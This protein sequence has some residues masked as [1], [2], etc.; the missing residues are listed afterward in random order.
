MRRRAEYVSSVALRAL[1]L[2]ALAVCSAACS[3]APVE[4]PASS[5]VQPKPAG[6]DLDAMDPNAAPGDD[7]YRYANGRWLDTAT[8]PQS[9]GAYGTATDLIRKARRSLILTIREA[10][11]AEY[12]AGSPHQKIGD[13]FIAYVD[14]DTRNALGMRPI[15]SEFEKIDRIASRDD[16]AWYLGDARRRG[17]PIPI[18][19]NVH[20]DAG[21]SDYY[22]L[23][24]TQAGLGLPDRD[25]YLRDDPA[26]IEVRDDYERYIA[27]MLTMA[28]HEDPESGAAL[29]LAFETRLAEQHLPREESRDWSA[30][31]KRVET[32]QLDELM[33]AFNWTLF[34]DA[35]GAAEVQ[36]VNL[37]AADY[38]PALDNIF[39]TTD[40]ATIRTWAKWSALNRRA[41]RLDERVDRVNFDFYGRKLEGALE[42]RP[43]DWRALMVIDN[44]LPDLVGR[45]YVE[46]HFSP[47]ARSHV[48]TIVRNV[49]LAY[50]ASLRELDWMREE[51]RAEAVDKLATFTAKIGYPDVWQDYREVTIR[52]DDLYGNLE[53]LATAYFDRNIARVGKRV[54]PREWILGPHVA[55]MSFD[56]LRYEVLL[57]AAFLQAPIFSLNVDDAVNYGAIGTM[58]AYQ[59]GDGFTKDGTAIDGDGKLRDWWTD[60]DHAEFER[61]TERLVQQFDVFEIFNDERYDK[62]F[63]LSDVV[64]DVGALNIA[65]KAYRLSL[66]GAEPPVIDNLTGVQRVLLGYA[67]SRKSKEREEA[68]RTT[69][70]T[71]PYVP[72]EYQVNGVVRNLPEF[73]EA[74][75]VQEGDALY[76]P[77]EERVRIW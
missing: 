11:A 65:L 19:V 69:M 42:Q 63:M 2:T 47:E 12:P 68:I 44:F 9:G 37:T 51:T 53:R 40:I 49:V 48:E 64:S 45:I 28:G 27:A 55:D 67:Q 6:L 30:H 46:R 20:P 18:E 14:M 22:A 52:R 26:S 32:D 24:A 58:V 17:L 15:Q 56:P 75:A 5:E 72:Y 76:L 21:N 29:V 35:M 16:V 77:P 7:F 3:V 8:I 43:R 70:A 23:Y 57:P 31:Y 39:A 38:F 36:S 60:E 61:R 4:P 66:N 74:F 50:D 25:Y 54:D 71:L 73:Y 1:L 13:L 59:I 62:A 41:V 33:P 10:V 34:L